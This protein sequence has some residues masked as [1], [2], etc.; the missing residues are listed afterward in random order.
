MIN[1]HSVETFGT[2]EGPG[3]RFVIFVQGCNFKCLYCHN[4]DSQSLTGSQKLSAEGL[5]EMIEK[6]LPYFG[7]K[8]GVTVSGGEPLLQAKEIGKLFKKLK[9]HP[10]SPSKGEGQKR[11]IH[12]ALDTNGSVLN[13]EVKEL[14]RYTDLVLLDI[15]HIDPVWHEK[16]TGGLNQ[17]YCHFDRGGPVCRQAGKSDN[18]QKISRQARDDKNMTVPSILFADYLHSQNIPFWIRYVLVPRCT[19]QSEHLN[20][21]AQGLSRYGNLERIEILPYHTMGEYKYEELGI[22]YKLKGVNPPTAEQI[23]KAKEILEKSGKKV[24]VR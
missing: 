20:L 17:N 21:M 7:D 4:P 8:G 14:L 22:E 2:H 23:Q 24:V 18:I 11:N 6:D 1:I 13:D 5:I 19:D 15:K 12:T 10:A 16:V 9:P 3:I